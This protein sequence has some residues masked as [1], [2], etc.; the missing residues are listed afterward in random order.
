MIRPLDDGRSI[1]PG[2]DRAR[3]EGIEPRQRSVDP[4]SSPAP[5]RPRRRRLRLIA[6]SLLI[7]LL[8]AAIVAPPVLKA[9]VRKQLA[10]ILAENLV[11]E[12]HVGEISFS[13]P[14]TV[15]IS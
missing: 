9:V 8:L 10:G 11:G 12:L 2:F 7:G 5:K 13:W 4:Q 1:E 15:D 6:L 14:W 3:S